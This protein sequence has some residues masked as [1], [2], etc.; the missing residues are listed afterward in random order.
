MGLLDFLPETAD[1]QEVEA[2][3][4][5][6]E[7]LR[8]FFSNRDEEARREMVGAFV[9]RI[10]E[11]RAIGLFLRLL[12]RKE[13]A[14]AETALSIAIVQMLR[15]VGESAVEPL[16]TALGSEDLLIRKRA[17]IALGEIGDQRAVE[18][19]VGVLRVARRGLLTRERQLQGLLDGRLGKRVDADRV[20][21][22]K[23]GRPTQ[24]GVTLQTCQE[25]ID[26]II[27]LFA[28]QPN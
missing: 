12:S 16:I 28:E 21:L 19:L 13:A 22:V 9:G 14:S 4:L 3:E 6:E 2:R 5:L 26:A 23:W 27:A 18:P 8:S 11:D 7:T 10:G 24:P 15:L 1:P 20:A 25:R 17:A